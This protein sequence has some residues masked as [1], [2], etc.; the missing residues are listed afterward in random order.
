[1][2]TATTH[3]KQVHGGYHIIFDVI[4]TP[5]RSKGF[6]TVHNFGSSHG[7]AGTLEPLI[8]IPEKRIYIPSSTKA[9]LQERPRAPVG[10]GQVILLSAVLDNLLCDLHELQRAETPLTHSSVQYEL[11]SR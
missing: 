4:S 2:L 11:S 6:V 10:F 7:P 1:M 8:E 5:I 9:L 3:G